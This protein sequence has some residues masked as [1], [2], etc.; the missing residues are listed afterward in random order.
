MA[1]VSQ[2]RIFR[3]LA[4]LG[5]LLLATVW[6]PA[7]PANYLLDVKTS[8]DDLPD[9][10]VTAIAQTPDGYLWI[11]TY[12]GLARFDGVRFV[13]FDP[14]TTPA[15]KNARITA[16]FVDAWGTLWI[17]T[18]DGSM[19]SLRNGIFTNEWHGGQVLGV[20]SKANRIFFTL[21]GHHSKIICREESGD[22][23]GDWKDV[24]LAG[25]PTGNSF[26]QD[27]TGT[28]WYTVNR[29]IY[30]IQGTNSE[31]LGPSSGWPGSRVN[32]MSVDSAGQLWIGTDNGIARWSGDHFEDQTPTNG[33]ANVNVYAVYCTTNGC[34]VF[35]DGQVRK[36]VDRRWVAEIDTKAWRDLVGTFKLELNAYED[37][38]G[39]LWL[40][41]L[42]SGLF[43]IR[44]DGST[45]H[46]ST[47][48]GLPSNLAACWFQ[49]REGSI[50]VGLT[51]GG[52]V[53]LRKREF[54]G[55]GPS[56][57]LTG[58]AIS[59][60]C[61]DAQSNIWIGT[62]SSGLYRCREESIERFDLPGG[63]YKECFFSIYPHGEDWLWLSAGREDL[64]AFE[65][66][67]LVPSKI[68]VH[69]IKCMLT[70]KSDRT[71]LG[72]SMGL[73]CLTNGALRNYS[74]ANGLVN[75]RALAE[76]VAGDIWIGTSDGNLFRF[77]DG[78]FAHYQTSD[79]QE[80]RAIWSLLP[81]NDGTLW[82][83]TFRGGLLRFKGGKFTRYTMHEGL[84][85][86][87]IPQIL[88][89]RRG[90][91]WIGSH[92][93][94]FSI[95]KNSFGELDA[96]RIKSLPCVS[97]G[98]SDGLPTLECSGNYQPACWR[99]HEGR[100]W[101]ATVK[102][103]VSVS[104]RELSINHIAPPVVIEAVN[105]NGKAHE[106]RSDGSVTIPSG[107]RQ[108]EFQ[109]T[110]LSFV[111][112]DKVVFRHKLEGF[113][114]DWVNSGSK[115]FV[116]YGVLPPG[117]YRFRVIACNNDGVWNESG[118]AVALI[119]EPHLWQTWWFEL[120]AAVV[121]LGAVFGTVRFVV[122]RKLHR[123]LEKL[124]QQQALQRE[125][126]R[127]AKDIHDDL[128]AGLTSI[129]LQSALAQRNRAG[130]TPG[131]LERISATA[132]DLVGAMD[133][134]V[135]A[136]DPEN[137]TLDAVVTYAGKFVQEFVTQAG[138]RCR[139]D[140]PAEIPP[141]TISSQERHH[142][143]L[144][145]KEVLNNAVKHAHATEIFFALKLQPSGFSFILKDNGCGF[146]PDEPR[147]HSGEGG[148]IAS[149]YGLRNLADRLEKIGGRCDI[150]SEPGQGTE[151][152]LT[153][154]IQN[155]NLPLKVRSDS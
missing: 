53:H 16:L 152:E 31:M 27:G 112:P 129:L 142:L 32:S 75:I 145:L 118:A 80:K 67:Q 61:E 4:C 57:G 49:D 73:S 87:I 105:V 154:I 122:T 88:D 150:R 110:A 138:L 120:M 133:E 146:S 15:L 29:T 96:G 66:N 65:N 143:F 155:K 23:H 71:W 101:F 55:I 26:A 35:G 2:F 22:K 14:V 113:D 115:R 91:L 43:H 90:S 111:A 89:D 151:V 56:P 134:I 47:E 128:G 153:V 38:D 103:P 98:L 40:A 24:T 147:A 70:D 18:Y 126:E 81:Q 9:S 86:D 123:K 19:T 84:P 78:E 46:L 95:S 36:C 25:G 60:I 114:E 51:R 52:L 140:L 58:Q 48:N 107:E 130:E 99:D 117:K 109:F 82:I 11:G 74:T 121:V 83:G 34:W 125:R 139:L 137:D 119:M 127:I 6:A 39:G 116:Q 42:G 76:D 97:Y 106:L 149:G 100:L 144:A 92:K 64:Y 7:D 94:I 69:G 148:R 3:H 17:N 5:F 136:I 59:S 50:W 54:R 62:F 77:H 108:L 41:H 132:T 33:A 30:R 63:A 68:V 104:P 28:L 85:S 72:K 131:H 1:N 20:Y 141:V 21:S 10:S 45:E 93:G 13:T 135:W 44:A 79:G 102:G 124:Q 37:R 8:D 12:N